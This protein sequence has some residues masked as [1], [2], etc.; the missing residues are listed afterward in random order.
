[1]EQMGVQDWRLTD[2]PLR[3]DSK[4]LS[5]ENFHCSHLRGVA[6]VAAKRRGEGRINSGAGS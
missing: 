4:L 6:G 1:M 3:S 5:R 2:N